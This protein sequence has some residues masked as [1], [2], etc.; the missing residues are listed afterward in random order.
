MGSWPAG[1]EIALHP[2]LQALTLEI[3]LRAVFGLE[4][5]ATLARL[6]EL[7]GEVLA[8]SKSPLSVL[9]ALQRWLRWTPTQRRFNPLMAETDELISR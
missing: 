3:I 1:E 5:G 6:R 2:R 9:P 4:R 7:L 8:F